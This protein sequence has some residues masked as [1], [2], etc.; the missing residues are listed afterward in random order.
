MLIIGH[1][2]LKR[3]RG[4]GSRRKSNIHPQLIYLQGESSNVIP[5]SYCNLSD[6]Q[7]TLSSQSDILSS[8]E[9]NSR[10]A[11]LLTPAFSKR[12]CTI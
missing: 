3:M 7:L 2:A 4:S 10:I 6:I 12:S 11:H 5:F 8:Y 1:T 9:S